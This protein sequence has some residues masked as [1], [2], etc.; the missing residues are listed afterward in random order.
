MIFV[1]QG[2]RSQLRDDQ[3]A[4]MTHRDSHKF[5]QERKWK[6]NAL[7]SL[8]NVLSSELGYIDRHYFKG[9]DHE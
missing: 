1:H 2:W 9:R 4:V 6:T 3:N 8:K 7:T 5:M